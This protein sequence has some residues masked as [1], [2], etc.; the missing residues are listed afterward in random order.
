MA[1]KK[2][3]GGRT[4]VDPNDQGVQLYLNRNL[5]KLQ[6]Q[7]PLSWQQNSNFNGILSWQRNSARDASRSDR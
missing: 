1:R 3:V 7:P 6:F 2:F 5:N 4:G